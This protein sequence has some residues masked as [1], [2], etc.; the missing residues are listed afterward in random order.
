MRVED[1]FDAA[2]AD[3]IER[4]VQEA[5]RGTSGEIVPMIVE[6]SDDYGIVRSTAAA[7]LAFAAGVVV[8]ALPVNPVLWLPPVQLLVFLFGYWLSGLRP[9]LRPLLFESYAQI[10]VRNAAR[11]AFLDHGVIETRDRS[12]ILIYVSLL[13]HRVEVVADRGIDRVVEPGTWDGVVDAVLDGIRRREAE[14][15][16]CNAIRICGE[17][18]ET[19]LPAR[20]DDTDEL[21]NKLRV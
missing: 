2:A 18:L 9:V 12:G 19:P 8:L 17:L 5:E 13:E 1:L 15:G 20:P 11:H 3:A 6:R 21:S 16:M 10:A 7:V 4:A 14:A